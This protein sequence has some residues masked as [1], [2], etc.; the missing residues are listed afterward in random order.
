MNL[1]CQEPDM[2]SYVQE[3][4][5]AALLTDSVATSTAY[6]YLHTGVP[7]Y[8]APLGPMITSVIMGPV[9]GSGLVL[10]FAF[11]R[12]FRFGGND[13]EYRR[14]VLGGDRLEQGGFR[15]RGN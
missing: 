10:A 12:C 4:T 3:T 14:F 13:H 11:G 7:G 5:A 2:P 9:S 15:F 8:A 6:Q 1:T